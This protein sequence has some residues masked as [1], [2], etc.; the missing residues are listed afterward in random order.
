MNMYIK[1]CKYSLYTK[2]IGRVNITPLFYTYGTFRPF[3]IYQLEIFYLKILHKLENTI[4]YF[5]S[6][7]IIA[8]CP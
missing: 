6:L 4:F 2:I 3:S 8:A 1:L 5:L 7:H